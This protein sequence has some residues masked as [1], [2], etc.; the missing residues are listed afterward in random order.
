[1][2]DQGHICHILVQSQ[3]SF[4]QLVILMSDKNIL[5]LTRT[6]VVQRTANQSE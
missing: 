6:N 3:I 4:L 1:M 5:K 2:S